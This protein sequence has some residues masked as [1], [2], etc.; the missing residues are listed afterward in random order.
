M[1]DYPLLNCIPKAPIGKSFKKWFLLPAHAWQV[2]LVSSPEDK[3][4][5]FQKVIFNL[6][7][8]GD[9]DV[10]MLSKFAHLHSDL[11]MIL[12]ESLHNLGL[13][14]KND[15]GKYQCLTNNRANEP[16]RDESGTET[17]GWVFQQ[18]WTGRLYPAFFQQ[19]PIQATSGVLDS[20]DGRKLAF[21]DDA[22]TYDIWAQ[23]LKFPSMKAITPAPKDVVRMI[24][25]RKSDEFKERLSALRGIDGSQTA[26]VEVNYPASIKRVKFISQQPLPVYLATAGL[27]FESDPSDWHVCCPVGTGLSRELRDL[28]IKCSDDG[29]LGAVTTV[30]QLCQRTRHGNIYEWTNA[31]RDFLAHARRETFNTFGQAIEG[32]PDLLEQ[33]DAFHDLWAR[34]HGTDGDPPQHL[35][36]PICSSAR[37]TLESLVKV[38]ANQRPFP[39]LHAYLVSKDENENT[40]MVVGWLKESG[41][42]TKGIDGLFLVSKSWLMK[43]AG[44]SANYYML[45]N[46]IGAIALQAKVQ[47]DHP[48][49][50][51]SSAYPDFFTDLRRILALGNAASHDNSHGPDHHGKLT[52]EVAL[53]IRQP[54]IRIIRALLDP[55][56]TIFKQD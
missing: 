17:V 23:F 41:Y 47:D 33:L 11:V 20:S 29:D 7:R 19:L 32:Y 38:F 54:L 28:I 18:P 26:D 5:V 1:N 22:R 37:K 16:L 45:K 15:E 48:L 13:L 43:Y 10:E 40:N 3:L 35:M 55:S 4:D 27:V 9:Y 25:L 14:K 51:A 6:M 24:S 49:R 8:S 52:K 2:I 42:D 46:V 34:L 21:G 53:S 36:E 31:R 12:L 44:E 50:I 56:G 30:N 39:E